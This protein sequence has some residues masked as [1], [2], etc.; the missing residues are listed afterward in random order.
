VDAVLVGC[1]VVGFSRV[2]TEPSV[3]AQRTLSRSA[4]GQ[5]FREPLPGRP[6]I[7]VVLP[8]SLGPVGPTLLLF[9]RIDDYRLKAQTT[10]QIPVFLPRDL[11]EFLII[12][13]NHNFFTNRFVSQQVIITAVG[14]PKSIL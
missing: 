5:V 4:P 1:L 3:E 12:L 8:L 9:Q 6:V 13:R 10:T 14:Q 2:P 7:V 11:K